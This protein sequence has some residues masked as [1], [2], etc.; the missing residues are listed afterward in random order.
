MKIIVPVSKI[1]V[2]IRKRL[3]L[4]RKGENGRTKF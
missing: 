3:D 1:Y 4:L 2:P